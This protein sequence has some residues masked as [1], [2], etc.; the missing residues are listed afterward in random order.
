MRFSVLSIVAAFSTM[1][2]ALPD[3]CTLDQFY[4]EQVKT[5]T[6]HHC[7]WYVCAGNN[8]WRQVR[9]CGPGSDCSANPTTCL[10]SHTGV[11]FRA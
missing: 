7:V 9:D 4:G 2:V 5:T 1:A 11:P 10:D 6:A 3:T 8:S